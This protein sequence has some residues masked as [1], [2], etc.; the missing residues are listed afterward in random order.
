MKNTWLNVG[1]FFLLGCSTPLSQRIQEVELGMNSSTV[2]EKLGSP[3]RSYRHQGVDRWVYQYFDSEKKKQV[4][5]IHFKESKV[6]YV[7]FVNQR[8][9]DSEI[10]DADTY[11]EYK[12]KV[13]EKKKRPPE[14]LYYED[15]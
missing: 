9:I 15:L 11:E 12:D 4:R 13:D 6:I 2:V 3:H 8:I 5:E 10:E 1:L 14:V 7:G